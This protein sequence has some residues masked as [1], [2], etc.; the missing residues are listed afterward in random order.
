MN[1]WNVD[2][3]PF[4]VTDGRNTT[5]ERRGTSVVA[6]QGR[7]GEHKSS[8]DATIQLCINL[9]GRPGL[10]PRPVVMFRGKGL[11]ISQ[12]ERLAYHRSTVICF[13]P[14]AYYNDQECFL[15]VVNH[16][17]PT[18]EAQNEKLRQPNARHVLF[19]D[20]LSGQTNAGF[21]EQLSHVNCERHLFPPQQTD[22]LQPVDRNVGQH[23]KTLVYAQRDKW[24]EVPE[25]AQRWFGDNGFGLS[26]SELRILISRWVGEA[27]EKFLIEL[28]ADDNLI[29][30]AAQ[31]TGCLLGPSGFLKEFQAGISIPGVQDY[32]FSEAD[33]TAELPLVN[34][35]LV[36]DLEE[37][38]LVVEPQWELSHLAD[39]E[40]EE[41][42][43]EP[44]VEDLPPAEPWTDLFVPTGY[45]LDPEIPGEPAD[46]VKRLVYLKASGRRRED[47]YLARVNRLARPADN[48]LGPVMALTHQV[49]YVHDRPRGA[50]SSGKELVALGRRQH[51]QTWY[52][53]RKQVE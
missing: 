17:A 27:W 5:L 44:D 3:V 4:C 10:Q 36:A 33:H 40:K 45:N 29:Y 35:S 42:L 53:L 16:F 31:R 12:A 32:S 2:Q 41:P 23:L 21:L 9:S 14:K 39:E 26:A 28:E 47:W 49:E 20:N 7:K 22:K 52:L 43:Q 37:A 18:I 1:R 24:L 13:S 15:W 38:R 25:N 51:G 34:E 30:K 50:S 48:Y 19:V 11:R 46:L 6:V 8:R